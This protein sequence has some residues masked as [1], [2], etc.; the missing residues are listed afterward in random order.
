MPYLNH[1]KQKLI[2]SIFS[3]D[4]EDLTE[5]RISNFDISE[6]WMRINF[7]PNFRI[8]FY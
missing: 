4:V 1:F 8:N 2:K 5:E 3:F 7:L 6:D